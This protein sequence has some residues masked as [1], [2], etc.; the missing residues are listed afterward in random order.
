MALVVGKH[1]KYEFLHRNQLKH[2]IVQTGGKTDNLY[3]KEEG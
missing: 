3:D 2:Q 1:G